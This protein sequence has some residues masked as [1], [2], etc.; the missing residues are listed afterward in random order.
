MHAGCAYAQG[1]YC[2]ILVLD[3]PI[4]VLALALE[5]HPIG[6]TLPILSLPTESIHEFPPPLQLAL[7]TPGGDFVILDS[8][9]MVEEKL[10]RSS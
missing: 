10:A 9:A 8:S 3:R 7:D 5:A 4:L 6:H 2:P 1:S